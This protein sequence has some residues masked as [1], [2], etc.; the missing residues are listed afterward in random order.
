MVDPPATAGGTDLFQVQF[1]T[2]VQSHVGL[3]FRTIP[4]MIRNAANCSRREWQRETLDD[5]S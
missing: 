2:F 1:L 4:L 3:K 5:E